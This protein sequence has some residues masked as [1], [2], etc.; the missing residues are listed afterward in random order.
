M[1]ERVD[2]FAGGRATQ[3]LYVLFMT[4]EALYRFEAS[5]GWTA[6][7]DG[8]IA[9]HSVGANTR[10]TPQTAQQPIIGFVHTQGGL[11]ANLA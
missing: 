6:G 10:V 8:S 7:V 3:A 9:R 2:R 1:T 5:R 11:M 4:Q